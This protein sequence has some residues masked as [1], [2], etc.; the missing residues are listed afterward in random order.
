M[1]AKRSD[2]IVGSEIRKMFRMAMGRENALDMTVGMPDFD[3]PQYIKDAAKQAIEEGYTR[4]THNAGLPEVREAF[5]EKLKRDNGIDADPMTE[6]ICTAGAM[7]S[8]LLTN[9]S[10]V[11]PGDEV[12]YP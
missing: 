11:D 12:I 1:L 8:L 6:I 10:I 5:A 3:T 4:Y 2:V 9:L 7:G